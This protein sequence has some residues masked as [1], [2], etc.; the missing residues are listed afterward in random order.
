MGFYPISEI[1]DL[2]FWHYALQQ[3]LYRYILNKKYGIEVKRMKLVVLHP[4]LDQPVVLDVPNMSD[5]IDKMIR[6]RI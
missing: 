2:P 3:N 5:A 1:E 4:S 6:T